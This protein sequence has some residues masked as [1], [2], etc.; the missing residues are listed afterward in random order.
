MS[1]HKTAN[2]DGVTGYLINTVEG[3]LKALKLLRNPLLAEE[4]KRSGKG[5]GKKRISD[6]KKY[7]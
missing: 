6:D 2:W 3:M 7:L 1:E 5:K 4:M